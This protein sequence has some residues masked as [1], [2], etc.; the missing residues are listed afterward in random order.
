[1]SENFEETTE[2]RREEPL[3]DIGE[4]TLSELTEVMI[5]MGLPKFR[6]AQVFEWIHRKKVRSFSEMTNLS[7]GLREELTQKFRMTVMHPER[8][9]ISKIDGTRKYV[10]SLYCQNVIE[11]VFMRYHHGNSVCISSQIGCRMGCTFCASTLD[12]CVRNLTAAEM[13]AEVYRIEADTGERVSNIVIMGSGEPFDNYEEVIRFIRMITCA[14]GADLSARNITLSTCGIVPGILKFAEEGLP[15]TLAL[16]LHAPNQELRKKIMPVAKAYPLDEVLD[17]CR[18]YFKRTGRRISFE[19]SVVKNVNDSE[20]HALE[21][22]KRIRDIHGHVNLIPVNPVEETGYQSPDRFEVYRF[23]KI[24]ND[25]GINAT[26]RREMGRDISSACGQLRRRHIN[27]T[28][29]C[30]N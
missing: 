5:S 17:A 8:V 1:M 20:T 6:A 12:G 22:A 13:L 21:L 14:D 29:L 28:G 16:S 18:T 2:Y 7:V 4:Y 10:F 9:L 24:L 15:V 26:I 11:A 3:P 23:Q 19:Y 30:K 27:D 25:Q